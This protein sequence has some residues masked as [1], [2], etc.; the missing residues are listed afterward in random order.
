MCPEWTKGKWRIG[1][2][3]NTNPESM[4]NINILR[5]SLV[6]PGPAQL[7]SDRIIAMHSNGI[8]QTEIAK[9]LGI[10]SSS[11]SRIVS[12]A[13]VISAR[14]ATLVWKGG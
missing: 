1:E 14:T 6:Q 9:T 7:Q 8:S 4:W 10:S 13:R 3:I 5:S 11:V 2:N 12:S